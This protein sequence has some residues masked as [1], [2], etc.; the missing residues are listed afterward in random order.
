VHTE[1][2]TSEE[3]LTALKAAAKRPLSA[4][5]LRAQRLSFVMG[6]LGEHTGL[7]RREVARKIAAHLDAKGSG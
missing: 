7:S 6:M 5:E 3:L 1:L 2:N 4:R